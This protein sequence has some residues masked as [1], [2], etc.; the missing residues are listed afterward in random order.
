[1]GR[2][3]GPHEPVDRLERE[4][5]ADAAGDDAVRHRAKPNGIRA[6]PRAAVV[7]RWPA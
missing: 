4:E 5:Q 2:G 7:H 1:M 3:R 6:P